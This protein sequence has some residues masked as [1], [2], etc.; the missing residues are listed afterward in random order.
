MPQP[1][2][3]RADGALRTAVVTSSLGVLAVAVLR[4]ALARSWVGAGQLL[5]WAAAVLVAG[6]C[7]LVVAASRTAVLAARGLAAGGAVLSLVGGADGVGLAAGLALL[8]TVGHPACERPD[9]DP[10]PP[11]QVL[12]DAATTTRELPS[13]RLTQELPAVPAG[14]RRED[15]P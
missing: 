15:A 10:D 1:T 11:T 4:L 6:A 12:D 2:P 8:A 9:A 13:V 7:C 14:G 3:V 5:P